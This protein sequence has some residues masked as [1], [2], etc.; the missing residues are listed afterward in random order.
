M[1]RA[2][3]RKQSN[4]LLEKA[5]DSMWQAPRSGGL[6]SPLARWSAEKIAKLCPVPAPGR[7]RLARRRARLAPRRGRP[8]PGRT[9]RTLLVGWNALVLVAGMALIGVVGEAYFQWRVP[10]AESDLPSA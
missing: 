7:G 3:D 2:M 10:F 6:S 8:A 5:R 1:T 9:R 4:D